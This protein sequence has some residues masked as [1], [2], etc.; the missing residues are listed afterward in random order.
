MSRRSFV[1]FGAAAAAGVALEGPWTRVLAQE[2]R[3]TPGATVQTTAGRIRGLLRDNVH[4]FKGVPYGAS[5]AGARRFLPPATPQSWTGVRD[6]FE[7][8]PRAPQFYGGEP[9]EM[10]VVDPREA[11]G[12]DCLVLNLWT[13]GPGTGRRPVMVWLHG[14]GY[15]S[16]SAGYTIYSGQELA[17][18]HDVVVVGV[19][20]R[21]NVFGF[22]YLAEIGGERY[23]TASNAGMLDIVAALEWVRDNIGAFGG[24][25]GNVTIFGQSGGAGKVSTL[26]AMPAA[27]GLFHKAIVQSG[28]ALTGVPR[29]AA[30]RTAETVLMRLGLGASQLDALQTMSME[31]LLEAT[32]GAGPGGG[33]GIQ[34]SPVVDGRSLPADPFEPSASRLSAGVPLLAGTTETE[35]TFFGGAQLGPINSAALRAQVKQTLGVDDA[36]ADRLIAVYRKNRPN[37]SPR[38]LDLIIQTDASP[39]RRGVDTEAE[40]QAA[41]PAPVYMYRFTWYSPVRNGELRAMHCMEI[42]FVFGLPDAAKEMTG[43][44]KERYELADRMSRAWTAFARTGTPGHSGLPAWK[45]FTASERATMLFNTECRLV[46]DPYREERLALAGLPQ[47]GR[48]GRGGRGGA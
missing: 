29:A 30:T 22:L 6:A 16:G 43:T 19:N 15:S 24:D 38:D 21:L 13:P 11:L 27:K 39:F 18:K 7:L 2:S 1:G 4:A 28:S 12:E 36:Q 26:M 20:H 33:G 37:A 41:Q 35:V 3:G 44:G 10:A 23:A 9:P 32:R 48:G 14:G 46:N 40:R 45:P 47:G 8:G 34:L 25:P 5:T 17:R 31:R 42:P